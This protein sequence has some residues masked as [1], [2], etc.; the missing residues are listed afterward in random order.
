SLWTL[1]V[2]SSERLQNG[3]GGAIVSVNLGLWCRLHVD[4]MPLAIRGFIGRWISFR[5]PHPCFP[6]AQERRNQF[7]SP[8]CL[9]FQQPARLHRAAFP[10]GGLA[11]AAAPFIDAEILFGN[12]SHLRMQTGAT[13]ECK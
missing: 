10:G 11:P 6:R 4:F 5:I 8:V 3:G 9:L 13:L 12:W 2:I 1:V 7:H